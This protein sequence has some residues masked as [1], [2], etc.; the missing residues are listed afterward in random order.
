MEH[1]GWPP[2][3]RSLGR[4]GFLEVAAGMLGAVV[5][6][7]P[8]L[9]WAQERKTISDK[10]ETLSGERSGMGFVRTSE[11]IMGMAGK[12]PEFYD[13]EILTIIWET[14]PEIVKRLL[15]APLKPTEKP[16]VSAFVADYPKTNFCL[17]YREAALFLLAEYDGVRGGYCLAMPVT[18]DM[19]MAGGRERF[20]YPKKIAD[21]HFA[22]QGAFAE[23]WAERHGV[24]YFRV[25]AE[26]AGLPNDASLM[27]FLQGAESGNTERVKYSYNFKHFPNPEGPGFDYNPRLIREAVTFKPAE[28]KIGKAEVMM[29]PSDQDPWAEV[30]VVKM[31]GAVYTKGNNTMQPGKIVAEVDP[32]EFAPHAFLR[33]DR[34]RGKR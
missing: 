31:L 34:F 21:I 25:K 9:T 32:V 1:H 16:I 10:P 4:R 33:W 12:R 7:S 27:E 28:T 24:R 5:L 26:L 2:R 20:G 23:G 22:K 13:A 19:A 15:P 30:E 18:N 29:N 8:G 3:G 6:G 11:E 14:K 17:P